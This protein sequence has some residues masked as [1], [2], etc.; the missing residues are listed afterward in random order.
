MTVPLQPIDSLMEFFSLKNARRISLTG[1][2]G[3]TTLLYALADD[4]RL[5]GRS[6]LVTTTTHIFRPEPE[7]AD[8]LL[9]DGCAETVLPES[10]KTKVFA[11]QDPVGSDKLSAPSLQTLLSAAPLF[12]LT[13]CEADGSK[14]LPFKVCRPDEPVP[15]PDSDVYLQIVGLSAIGAPL[16]TCCHRP[17][18]ACHYLNVEETAVLTPRLAALLLASP[19]S[20]MRGFPSDRTRLIF[21]QADLP[22][23]LSAAAETAA[24]L[25]RLAGHGNWQEVPRIYAVSIQKRIGCRL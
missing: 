18:L 2:G 10:G 24:H 11:A 5:A 1:A 25:R 9:L 7:Q 17:E 15:L 16:K 19:L 6:V 21:N 12:D 13:L 22:D 14:R 20:S 23:A 3:K 4:S 8:S